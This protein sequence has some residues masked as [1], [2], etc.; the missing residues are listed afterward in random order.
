MT[1][2]TDIDLTPVS[3]FQYADKN[4]YA[5]LGGEF[6]ATDWMQLRAGY[7]VDM[8]GNDH[9]IVTGGVGLS[10]GESMQFDLTAMAGRTRTIGGVAQ[11]TFYF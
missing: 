2:S 7:R 4:Q 1:L 6:R 9:R 3:D 8:R 11:F 10:A 5:A